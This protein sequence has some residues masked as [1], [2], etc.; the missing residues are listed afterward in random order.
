MTFS[1]SLTFIPC[2]TAAEN[3]DWGNPANLPAPPIGA[4]GFPSS[5]PDLDALTGFL[6][7][8]PGYGEVPFWWWT[9]DPLDK[10]RLLWQ[11]REL[12]RKG[13]TG[14]QVNYAHQDTPGWPTY[15]NEPEIFTDAWWNMWNT[16]IR[17]CR[18]QGMGVG[19]SGYTLDWPG[20]E[21]NLFGKLL[22]RDAALNGYQLELAD[23]VRT[24]SVSR[25]LRMEVPGDVLCIRAYPSNGGASEG[26][27]L[28]D[29]VKTGVLSWTPASG[30]WRVYVI[31]AVK[32]PLTLDPINPK[33]G[34][35]V[36]ERFFQPFEDHSPDKSSAGLNYF[37]QDELTFGVDGNI[38]TPDFASEFQKR[39]GYD[40]LKALPAL[41]GDIGTATPKVRLD[42][43]DVKVQLMEERYFQPIFEWHWKRGLIYGCDPGSRGRNPEEFG[44]YFRCV[45]WYT[46][47]GHD[48]PGG[49]ADLIK[50]KVSSSIAHLYK[51]PRV[52]LEGYH[53]LGWGANPETLMKA[54]DEN[55]LFGCTLLNLHGLY[56]TTHGSFW[57][58]APPCYHFRM[59]YWDHMGVFLKY[60]ER[61]SYLLSQGVHRCDVAILYPV[62]PFQAGMDGG[63]AA[64]TAFDAGQRLMTDGR[65][66]DFI[67]FQSLTRAD[68]RDGKLNVSGEAYRALI[69]PSMRAVRWSTVQKALAFKRAGGIVIA[70]GA[71]PEASDRAGR[72]D[73]E[74]TAA[75]R[76]LFG[77]EN[78][79]MIVDLPGNLP[80]AIDRLVSRDIRSSSPVMAQHRKVGPRDVYMTLGAAKGSDCFFRAQGKAELWDPWTGKTRPLTVTSRTNEGTTVRMPLESYEAQVIVFSP[81][82]TSPSVEATDL[83]EIAA[84]AGK[85]GAIKL[86]GYSTVGGRK[87]ATVRLGDH[88]ATLSGDAAQ[89][90][91]SIVL[92]GPWE[93]E[94]KPTLDNRW[95]DFRLPVTDRMI[96]AEARLFRYAE[97]HGSSSGWQAANFDDSGWTRAGCDF[98]Q[99]FWKLGP[100]PD[101]TDVDAL[102]KSL[103]DIR[104]I[105]PAVPMKIGGKHYFWTPYAF[106]W[107]WGVEGDPGHQGWHGL[108]ESITDDFICL[109]APKDGFNATDY[110]REE[111]G[112][113][114]YLWTAASPATGM[115]AEMRIG[116]LAPDAIYINGARTQ[117]KG[118]VSLAAGPNPLLL[119][120]N[121]P[122]RGH[123]VLEQ[124]GSK[125][126]ASRTPL[127]MSWFDRPGIAPYDA[128]SG[129][130]APVGWYRFT[131][132]PGLRGMTVIARG[133]LQAWVNGQPMEIK[134]TKKRSDGTFEYRV[135]IPK[136]AAEMSKVAFRIV[137]ER[138]RYGGSA[139]PEPVKLDCGPGVI[140]LGDWSKESVLECY[141][142]GAWYRKTVTLSPEQAHG[143]TILD[144]GDITATAEVR[145]N[146][147]LAGIRVAPPW[148][149]DIT[150]LVK[151]GKNRIEILVYNTLANHYLTIPTRYHGSNRSGLFGPVRIEMM[152]KVEL[153][154]K[155]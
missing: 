75:V 12:K 82:D 32:K 129:E 36:I 63:K 117:P 112:S 50:D 39:K 4:P 23:S 61:L 72:N 146:G 107:R 135:R 69:F 68:I 131:A 17:E 25:P 5:A 143:R 53:S 3:S 1:L 62:D 31:H 71:L 49:K 55:F 133:V 124:T 114:Y 21:S 111:A 80:A 19:L 86:T 84:L 24:V 139:L 126:E 40:I 16:T 67:D 105:D 37:F 141:S 9:G 18:K 66:F 70:L 147:K 90:A 136:P 110:T 34:Q 27:D 97:E 42:Y 15:P 154:E 89:P 73:P 26:L 14:M 6:N 47:P 93:F 100:L 13:V 148:K 118:T 58:W 91:Q 85:N 116:G 145:I 142:G 115:T 113:R 45:R 44:D 92:E 108:K 106:S 38:W 102:D 81:A 35:S 149:V 83:D 59:P 155:L 79:G 51:R 20:K 101:D 104:H 125:Q 52:W 11:I 57:E 87:S 48:T 140:A 119:R 123:F 10:D 137:Q 134:R 43:A 76:E 54:T 138:G 144:L 64:E 153:T 127:S 120:Y 150:P 8:P 96:G 128:L 151:P 130:A 65:D 22:Y 77:Q 88:T 41:F 60:F 103:A 94:L 99:K 98:G 28:A 7:P 122:G 121:E 109:G 152:S 132:P 30:E 2:V 46:A 95:G 33:A 29:K 78:S 56:Y 74:L